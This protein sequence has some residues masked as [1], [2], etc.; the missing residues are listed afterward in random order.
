MHTPVTLNPA[1]RLLSAFGLILMMSLTSG[2]A[3]RALMS[4]DRYEKTEP[5]KQQFHSSEIQAQDLEQAYH[6]ALQHPVIK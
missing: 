5:S 6:L 3:T 1:S 4:S 2:C